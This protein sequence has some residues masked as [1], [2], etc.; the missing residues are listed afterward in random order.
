MSIMYIN[1]V[2]ATDNDALSDKSRAVIVG[3]LGMDEGD[4]LTRI[5]EQVGQSIEDLAFQLLHDK[6]EARTIRSNVVTQLCTSFIDIV[7]DDPGPDD[8]DSLGRQCPRHCP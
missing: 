8:P 5:D 4:L 3:V 1:F 6:K 2:E 7:L